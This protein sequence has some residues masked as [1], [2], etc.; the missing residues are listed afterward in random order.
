MTRE[1]YRN[2]CLRTVVRLLVSVVLRFCN[3]QSR[4]G[5]SLPARK[6]A[7]SAVAGLATPQAAFASFRKSARCLSSQALLRSALLLFSCRSPRGEFCEPPQG[8]ASARTAEAGFY[9]F[10]LHLKL[11]HSRTIRTAIPIFHPA[12]P[13]VAYSSLPRSLRIMNSLVPTRCADRSSSRFVILR[14]RATKNLY[15]QYTDV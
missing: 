15:G 10:G 13:P 14:S 11:A 8:G 5:R 6:L 4:A 1:G 12:L 9:E 2:S 7:V 3:S